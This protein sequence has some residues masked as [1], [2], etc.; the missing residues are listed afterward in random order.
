[1]EPVIQEIL[2]HISVLNDDYT[3]LSASLGE[4]KI[5]VAVIKSQMGQGIWF[6]RAIMGA[7]IVLG[8]TQFWQIIT[9]KKNGKK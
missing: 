1:M 7:F 9:M 2:Q 5:D 8:V 3:A 4:V 6:F